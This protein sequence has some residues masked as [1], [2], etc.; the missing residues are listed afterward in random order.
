MI[1]ITILVTSETLTFFVIIYVAI[2]LIVAIA[3][4]TSSHLIVSDIF[5]KLNRKIA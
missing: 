1:R 4:D 2:K 3:Q 5:L